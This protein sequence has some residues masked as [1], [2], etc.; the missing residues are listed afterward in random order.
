MTTSDKAAGIARLSR[1]WL[2]S[3]IAIVCIEIIRNT[4]L[5]V[6]LFFLYFAVIMKLPKLSEAVVLIIIRRRSRQ[7]IGRPNISAFWVFA[8]LILVPLAGWL[9]VPGK[10]LS[11]DIPELV[12]KSGGVLKV[13]GGVS[14][15]SSPS[16]SSSAAT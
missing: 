12:R 9:I 1:N 2:V 6:Q 7:R 3:K 11:L 4:P 8:C 14:F 13:E 5:L 10:P 16:C 15:S